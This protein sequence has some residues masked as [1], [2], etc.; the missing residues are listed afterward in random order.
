MKMVC[1][2]CSQGPQGV[3]GTT[4][5][6]GPLGDQGWTGPQGIQGQRG[7]SGPSGGDQGWTG[8][9]GPIGPGGGDQGWT[10]PSGS[11]GDQGWTGPDGAAGSAG[12]QGWTGPDGN[13]G[14]TGPNEILGFPITGAAVQNSLLQFDATANEWVSDITAAI[15]IGAN[16]GIVNQNVTAIAIGVN[17][18]YQ[19]Q[20][21]GAIAI[22]SGA[23]A[24]AGVSGGQA[25][26]TIAIGTNSSNNFQFEQGI[27]IGFFAGE[28]QGARSIAIG[29]DGPGSQLHPVAGVASQHSVVIGSSAMHQ[30]SDYSIAIGDR[31]GRN[32]S[33][34]GPPGAS[35]SVFIGRG[36]D[37]LASSSDNMIVIHGGPGSFP[38]FPTSS[39]LYVTPIASKPDLAGSAT[40][41][42][43]PNLFKNLV[44]NPTSF[45]I[46]YQP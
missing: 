42:N 29:A 44:Y 8:P 16:S 28:R 11:A 36:A 37:G 22:G 12:D 23:G 21:G 32:W 13:Q 19:E 18:G 45:E 7:N 30:P 34:S 41:S 9:L 43:M 6:V 15:H 33:T 46:A 3:Q 25:D 39:G 35:G 20:S 38:G 14:W 31:A 1:C 2:C 5:N 40:P 24:G 4:G 17:S 27:A 10:G 26:N